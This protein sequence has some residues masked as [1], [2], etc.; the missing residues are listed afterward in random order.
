MA[1]WFIPAL[2]AI[3][4]HVG[5]IVGAAAPV[6]TRKTAEKETD[7][8]VLIGK[9]IAELQAAAA[10][11]A[12]DTKELAGQLQGVV[13]TLEKAASET[14]SRLRRAFVLSSAAIVVS[15]CAIGAA[16]AALVR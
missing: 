11:N 4:P 7:P 2:K 15:V 9:Q 14:E 1:A 8:L 3:L 6:F 13:T 10:K 16:I 12:D 5:T